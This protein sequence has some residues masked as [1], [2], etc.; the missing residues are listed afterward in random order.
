MGHRQAHRGGDFCPGGGK[1]KSGGQENGVR[2]GTEGMPRSS[3]I[4]E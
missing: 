4:E 2:S 3:V 1:V